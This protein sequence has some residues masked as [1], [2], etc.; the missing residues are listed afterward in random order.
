M[1]TFACSEANWYTVF[2]YSISDFSRPVSLRTDAHLSHQKNTA[3]QHGVFKSWFKCE[4]GEGLNSTM[5]PMIHQPCIYMYIRYVPFTNTQHTWHQS[6][7][8]PRQQYHLAVHPACPP[9]SSLGSPSS[10]AFVTLESLLRNKQCSALPCY[11]HLMISHQE[12]VQFT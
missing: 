5:I 12:H 6:T 3:I 8:T 1:L 2:L 7:R 4:G 10:T 9:F 11:M